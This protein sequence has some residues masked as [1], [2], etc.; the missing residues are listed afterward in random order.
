[1]ASAAIKKPAEI[2]SLKRLSGY[3]VVGTTYPPLDGQLIHSSY[4][5][6]PSLRKQEFRAILLSKPHSTLSYFFLSLDHAS[7]S[8]AMPPLG[9]AV[10][11][12]GRARIFSPHW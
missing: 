10:A 9:P 7:T 6:G 2:M 5:H 4:S 3:V 1:M 8:A 12:L 11:D